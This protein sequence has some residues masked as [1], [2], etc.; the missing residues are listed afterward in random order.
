MMASKPHS[1]SK[2]VFHYTYRKGM[3]HKERKTTVALETLG[4]KLNQAETETLAR[5]FSRAG[6]EVTALGNSA[7]IYVLNTCTVTHIAD[8]KSRHLLRLARRQNPHAF[9]IATGCFAQRAADELGEMGEVDL[10][11]GN[12]DKE[13]LVQIVEV[14]RGK[15]AGYSFATS[16]KGH[17]TR[18]M[19]KIQDG[20]E[21]FCSY[22]I[23]PLVRGEEHSL[24]MEQVI[25]EIRTRVAEGYKE[26][27]LTG[28]QIGHYGQGN[29]KTEGVTLHRLVQRI[30]AE[31]KV[32]RLR[33]S[34]I[35]PQDVTPELLWLWADERLCPHFHLSLQSGN[36][37]VLGRM[38]RP[39]SIADYT[40][41]VAMIREMVPE[42]AITTDVIVGFPGES[43]E[44]FEQSYRF[45]ERMGFA[46]MHIFPYSTRPGTF[47]CQMPDQVDERVKKQRSQQM[48]ELAGRSAQRFQDRFLGNQ[49]IV[50]WETN[51]DG[52]WTG[53]TGNYIRVYTRYA[54]DLTN[55]LLCAKLI[56][57]HKEGV[58]TELLEK[59][60]EN[61]G[62]S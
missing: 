1:R 58:W 54:E 32:E 41:A 51:K 57:K 29:S 13:R 23:V 4:C 46:R 33:L 61:N 48:L 2:G 24:P 8:R 22:C 28:T 47:A 53:L 37:A 30:L 16:Y 6:Y 10:V 44:E 14:K 21:Q 55:R 20:C 59:G 49:A 18:A 15:A 42:V 36:D 60:G 11:V 50:L 40:K 43:E 38:R 31:T 5:Q 7:D 3:E 9:I 56:C 27:L 34:S 39:Y 62:P 25:Q 35:Q 52:T 12:N 17:R 45:C 26:I 19:V